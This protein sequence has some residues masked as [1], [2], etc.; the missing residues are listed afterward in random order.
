MGLKRPAM[1]L[2]LA[3]ALVLGTRVAAAEDPSG[4]ASGPALS[5]CSGHLSNVT[6]PSSIVVYDNIGYAGGGFY[7]RPFKDYVK[8][9]LWR[10]WN[11]GWKLESLQAGAMAVMHYA[12]YRADQYGPRY[13]GG[14]C[15]DIATSEQV[16]AF[17][18]GGGC[19]SSTNEAVNSVFAAGR[20]MRNNKVLHAYY[21]RGSIPEACGQWNGGAAPGDDMSQYGTKA[22][23]EQG[24]MWNIIL[25][26][27]YFYNASGGANGDATGHVV[28]LDDYA[29]GTDYNQPGDG[30][31]MNAYTLDRSGNIWEDFYRATTGAWSGWHVNLGGSCSSAPAALGYSTNHL[32]LFCRRAD[33]SGL[34]YGRLSLIHI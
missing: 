30:Y 17:C 28:V 2:L 21:K 7:T 27:Y 22:C 31:H 13:A 14:Q 12:W 1:L 11:S 9:V 20:T 25:R 8:E 26:K 23:A 24:L 19:P 34:I 33:T 4:P 29:G 18:P 6:P 10:E 5:S 32:W 16:W 15:F 3:G